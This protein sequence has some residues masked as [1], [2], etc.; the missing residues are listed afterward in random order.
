MRG[1]AKKFILQVQ[2]VSLQ[3][4]PLAK[5]CCMQVGLSEF[6][7]RSYGE[8]FTVSPPVFV[9]SGILNKLDKLPL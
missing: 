4:T 5:K 2:E 7:A 8:L 3:Q 9:K 6:T 1:K